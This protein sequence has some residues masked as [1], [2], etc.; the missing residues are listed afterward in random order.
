M[1]QN[2]G[3]VLPRAAIVLLGW[4]ALYFIL[5]A[6]SPRLAPALIYFSG[7]SWVLAGI[8]CFGYLYRLRREAGSTPERAI[9]M[10]PKGS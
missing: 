6:L 3:Y 5:T 1:A 9:T 8:V 7:I 10:R 2:L 4:G